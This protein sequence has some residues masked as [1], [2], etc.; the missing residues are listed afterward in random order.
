MRFALL[1]TLRVADG[2]EWREL[3]GA[4]LR[5]LLALLLLNSGRVVSREQLAEAGRREDQS[6]SSLGALYNHMTR[7]RRALGPDLGARIQ[8]SSPGY[9]VRLEPG[10]L[11]ADVFEVGLARGQ[12]ALRAGTWAQAREEF[13]AALT[14]WRDD[15]LADVPALHGHSRAMRLAEARMTA[16]E[17]RIEADLQLGR[18]REVIGELRALV[19]QYPLRESLHAN[20]M[21]ALHR[22][23]L[24]AEA[25]STFAD[26]R[27]TLAEELGTDPGAALQDLHQRILRRD[28]TL[29]PDAAPAPAVSPVRPAASPA[30]PGP[31]RQLPADTRLFTGRR[32]ELAEVLAIA[33]G[34]GP[35]GASETVV[36]SAI[37]GMAGIGKS[38]LAVHLGHR[39]SPEFPDGALFVDLRGHTAGL[40]PLPPEVALEQL[41]R[42]LGVPARQIT[43]DLAARAALFRSRIAGTRTLIVLDNAA[44]AEQVRPLLPGSAGCLVLI[45][46]RRQLISLDDAH[47]LT[48]DALP[49][50]DAVALLRNAAG[51]GRVAADDP[52][53]GE[54]AGLCGR[55]PLGIRIAAA[56]LRHRPLL[57]V[58]DLVE[59]LRQEGRRLDRL[60]DDDRD[61]TAV[62]ESSYTRLPEPERHLLRCLGLAT[63]SDFDAYAAAALASLDLRTAERLLRSLADHN[64]LTEHRLGR[65][66]FHD[67]VRIYAAQRARAHCGEEEALAIVTRHLSWTLYAVATFIMVL[68]PGRVRPLDLEPDPAWEFPPVDSHAAALAWFDAEHSN[69]VTAVHHAADLGLDEIAWQSAFKLFNYVILCSSLEDVLE[70]QQR[71]LDSARRC[72]D[73]HGQSA[74]LNTIA[75]AHAERG[76]YQD[77]ARSLEQALVIRRAL[78]NRSGEAACLSNLGSVYLGLRDYE[79][80]ADALR[81]A[82]EI[83]KET[84]SA[85]TLAMAYNSLARVLL[86][87]S[88]L[89]EARAAYQAAA[90]SHEL[91]G[92]AIGLAYS[93]DGLAS[94]DSRRGELDA[95][96]DLRGRAAAL[97][98]EQNDL[99]RLAPVLDNLAADEDHKGLTDAA[100]AHRREAEAIRTG[101]KETD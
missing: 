38:A 59:E 80:S 61:L 67:L 76:T 101:L 36:I 84:D 55:L 1:G 14:L 68:T 42:S 48:L 8:T 53:A 93:L 83:A 88:E 24:S 87:M 18:H 26:L 73:A 65:Y 71:G 19:K 64:L 94:V 15:V 37:S 32:E 3:D 99:R 5:T 78:G 95:A 54:L 100:L 75:I 47:S 28:P 9:V 74:L 52:A 86:E 72:G 44:G 25:L 12:A 90:E 45:T 98:R 81:Q 96:L 60:R 39:L 4:K 43:G 57:G 40:E 50:A 22:D 89:T 51:P 56:H 20:L 91:R 29:E 10:E 21:L 85:S 33:R 49:D 17:G 2:E 69:L 30:A 13:H 16:Q 66:R 58:A 23:G 62:F 97:L 7:L 70:L 34:G 77:A 41:L 46:S 31:T 92:D 6:P 35:T 27:G 63:V 79:K 11:D 82:V